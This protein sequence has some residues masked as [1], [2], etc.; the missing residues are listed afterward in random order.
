MGAVLAPGQRTVCA[1]L[2][3]LGWQT[4]PDFALYHQVLNRARWSA[5]AASR[6]LLK[7]LLHHLDPGGPLVFGLD[8]TIERRSGKRIAAKGVYRD[9]VRSS[10]SHFVKAMG[11]RR[12]SLMWLVRIPWAGRVWAL[13]FLTVLA[14]SVRHHAEQGRRHKTLTRW[15]RRMLAC[16]RRWLPDREL[17]VVADQAYA[18]LHLLAACQRWALT[19]VVRLRLDA[20]LYAPPPPRT[21]GQKGRPRLKGARLP[22]PQQR[23]ED[24]KT[25]WTPLTVRGYDGRRKVLACATG[26]ALWYPRRPARCAPPLGAAAGPGRGPGAHGPA[27]HRPA[28]HPARDRGL[29]SAPLAG[30]GRVPGRARP[31]GRGDPAPGV[32]PRHRPHHPPCCWASRLGH[33]DRPRPAAGPAPAPAPG[34]LVR[35]DPPHLRRCPGPRAHHPL[36]RRTPFVPV[37]TAPRPAKIPAARPGMALGVPGLHRLKATAAGNYNRIP[38]PRSAARLGG[39]DCFVQSRAQGVGVHLDV[40]APK[41]VLAVERNRGVSIGSAGAFEKSRHQLGRVL[42]QVGDPCTLCHLLQGEALSSEFGEPSSFGTCF[43]RSTSAGMPRCLCRARTMDI[44][45]ER[46]PESTSET[47]A[48]LP[49]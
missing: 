14:P 38:P 23:L 11:L 39:R 24:P 22:S 29:V 21:P 34:R 49:M 42:L 12:I 9:A 10:Q 8:E 41:V 13:P 47:L 25:V 40:D 16:L 32:G 1:C 15:A 18:A 30:G 6:R 31:P 2:R 3:A 48:R 26:T 27:L 45:I 20:A 7:L 46:F 28:T 44:V 5:L 17:V 35:Q 33:R 4:E 36:D 43:C 37:P 19:A